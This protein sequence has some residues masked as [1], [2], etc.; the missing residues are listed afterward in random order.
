MPFLFIRTLCAFLSCFRVHIR[1]LYRFNERINDDDD[2]D[3]DDDDLSVSVST[4]AITTF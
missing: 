1:L 3:N 4:V 2:D